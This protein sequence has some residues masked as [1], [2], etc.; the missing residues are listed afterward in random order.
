VTRL[1]RSAALVFGALFA[2]L[3]ASDAAAQAKV[4]CVYDPSGAA[5]DAYQYAKDYQTAAI[6]WGVTFEPKPYTSETVAAA[7]FRNGKCDAVILTG[8]RVQQFN[9]KT[10][11]VEAI[12]ALPTQTATAT[13]VKTLMKEKAA[14]LMKSGDYETAGI[15]PAGA[16]YLFLRDRKVTDV[17]ALAGKKICTL[18]YDDAAKTMVLHVGATLEPADIGTFASKFN[19]GSCD[20]AYAPASA[21]KPL[22]LYKGIGTTGGIVSFP[23]AQFTFQIVLRTASFPEGFGQKSRDW[24][25][26]RFDSAMAVAARAEQDVPASTWIT[27]PDAD[28]VK[29]VDMLDAVRTSLVGKGQYDATIVKLLEQIAAQ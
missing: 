22:E 15:F 24:T 19:N 17:A 7:D 20:A 26:T 1:L 21:Y 3:S 12:G 27:I 4:L 28:H 11:S 8:V 5:G 18:D 6:A 29:Y 25:S 9:R 14:S 23:L 2:T 10:Y 16:V 13:A